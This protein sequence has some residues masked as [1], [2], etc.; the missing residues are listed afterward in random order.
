MKMLK[1]RCSLT[2]ICILLIILNFY[3]LSFAQIL[4]FK[5]PNIEITFPDKDFP[6]ILHTL[7]TGEEAT[8]ILTY[9][10]PNNYESTKKYPLVVYIP[11]WDGGLK[12]NI[13]N[14]QTIADSNSWIV[15]TVPLFK[16]TIDRSEP[17]GGIIVSME[18]FPVI[19]KCY[20]IMFEKLFDDVPNIDFNNSTIVGY[21]N[22]AITLAVL[23]SM[24]DEFIISHFN[25]FCLV[26]HGMFHLTDLHKHGSRDRQYLILVGDQQDLGRDLKIQRSKLLQ[27][28]MKLVGVNLTSEIM[29]D[30]GHEFKEEQMV[31][32]RKWIQESQK[33]RSV[34]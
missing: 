14:A 9:R 12:G 18:D 24:H 11:G 26:D 6:P 32:V 27:D 31:L 19:S 15:A 5:N 1:K 30:T 3:C 29:K 7:M 23:I 10:L 8:P 16:K 21:S 28:E 4:P 2:S 20:R 34:D 33:S 17:G 13:K 22:G 25:N